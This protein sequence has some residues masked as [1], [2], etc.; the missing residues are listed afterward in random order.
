MLWTMGLPIALFLGLGAIAL[1]SF[2]AVATWSDNRRKEREAYYKS[3]S[4][5]KIAE[6]DGS[7]AAKALD[8]MREEERN[9]ARRR[10]EGVKL[11]GLVTVAAG[12][13]LMVF[14]IIL[15]DAEEGVYMV[16]LIP[17]LIGAA[18]LVY[19]YIFAS[20]E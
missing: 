13:G 14:L 5:K 10:R 3:E 17:F 19:T 20:K 16:G 15:E 4:L 7:S 9:A 18:L 2:I 12:I 1:F 8:Y 11:G 6:M